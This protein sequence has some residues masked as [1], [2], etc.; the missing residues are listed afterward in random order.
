MDRGISVLL[1]DVVQLMTIGRTHILF[2]HEVFKT[3]LF[4]KYKETL[5]T[6]CSTSVNI[7]SHS[8]KVVLMKLSSQPTN[9]H[10]DVNGHQN[11]SIYY[12]CSNFPQINNN[13]VTV[14]ND[15]A[16]TTTFSDM[17][18]FSSITQGLKEVTI[19]L[20]HYQTRPLIPVTM[21]LM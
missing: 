17:Q 6:F 21:W 8:L 10:S 9:L 4:L 2:D 20:N 1:Q 3:E 19:H 16:C 11:T 7:V 5:G 18:F 12:L 13:V 15:V 14:K